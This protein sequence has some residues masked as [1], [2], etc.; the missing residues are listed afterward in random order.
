MI[1]PAPQHTESR[2]IARAAEPV[3]DIESWVRAT[4]HERRVHP[5]LDETEPIALHVSRDV[6]CS[7]KHGCQ[8]CEDMQPHYLAA[9]TAEQQRLMRE[10]GIHAKYVR[11]FSS[12]FGVS[13]S[14]Y[15]TPRVKLSAHVRHRIKGVV[16]ILGLVSASLFLAVYAKMVPLAEA[17]VIIA[18]TALI[19]TG[20]FLIRGETHQRYHVMDRIARDVAGV[21]AVIASVTL[22]LV[23]VSLPARLPEIWSEGSLWE[24]ALMAW[25][26]IFTLII[27]LCVMN[28]FRRASARG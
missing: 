16:T 7:G 4:P 3:G 17:G 24:P 20:C 14:V 11:E 9:H 6:K 8:G 5:S 28:S 13:S 10:E 18:A 27:A 26:S 21:L 22:L 15:R 25:V 23:A 19:V 12:L 1:I 2:E